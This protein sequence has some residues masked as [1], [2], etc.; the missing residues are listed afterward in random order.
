MPRSAKQI[1]S[2]KRNLEKGKGFQSTEEAR[3]NG[4][5][6]GKASGKAKREKKTLEQQIKIALEMETSP[7]LKAQLQKTL[8][9][10]VVTNSE[11]VAASTVL[12][13]IKGNNKA[14]ELVSKAVRP[15]DLSELCKEEELKKLK[16]ENEQKEFELTSM[17]VN[18][19]E[20]QAK[21]M[22]SWNIPISDV[23][24]D[25][26]QMYRDVHAVYEG[27]LNI[28]EMIVKGGRG[29]VKS[30]FW[31][32]IAEETIYQDPE[33][34][35][36]YTRRYKT[37]LRGSVFNQF[38]RTVIRH[39]RIDDWE[40]KTQ[41][42][43][44]IYKPTKQS[45]M[46]VGA[47]KPISL[48]SFSVQFGYVK[49]LI[50]E[51]CDE[52][53]GLEQM[54]NIEDTFLRSDT[55]ALDVKIFNPPKSINNFMNAY[56]ADICPKKPTTK[57]Y[58]SY[59]YNVPVEWL[60]ERFFERAE[61]FKALKPNYYRNNY[62]GEVTGTGGAIFENVE[63]REITDA[64]ISNM[65]YFRYGLDF[66]YEHPQ[67]FEA[68]YYDEENNILYCIEEIV[69]KRCKNATFARAIKHHISDEIICDSARPD[70]IKD[71]YDWGY[72]V[73]GAKKRWG[74]GKGRDYCWEWLQT[75]NKIV[76]D[77]ARCPQLAHELTTL[78]HEQLKDGTFTAAYPTIGE[79][80][81]M[82]LIYGLNR[83]I[84]RGRP[85]D[86]YD[87]SADNAYNENIIDI[88]EDED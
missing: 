19:K 78:E 57:I 48:K 61:E 27:R 75:C 40:F 62:L 34:H 82:A 86:I 52:M 5:K 7:Q 6:G 37:D 25:F 20:Q 87:T 8:G 49:L 77:P 24:S 22:H 15:T 21:L 46:F 65:P 11:A 63:L 84:M 44:A 51:E 13:A 1:E 35:V 50:H 30:S 81:V 68:C 66:G 53:A 29:S 18:F 33:A 72:N 83:D 88:D 85:N 31:A 60:G 71:M 76:V 54:D 43:M 32:A 39:G 4:Q 38:M 58:H 59:Y 47:D 56:V 42:M 55:P 73:I 80:A 70:S 79:D 2:A 23:T 74:N 69:K 64:E 26:I 45:V 14:I 17:R 12:N 41:P 16:L 3:K 36:V 28:R 9:I 10:D 67:A